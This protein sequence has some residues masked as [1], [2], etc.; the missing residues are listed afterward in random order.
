MEIL[1]IKE[2]ERN[3]IH[4]FRKSLKDFKRSIKRTFDLSIL[5]ASVGCIISCSALLERSKL[6]QLH[7]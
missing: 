7:S 6:Y 2:I 3:Y 1:L 4:V 5:E